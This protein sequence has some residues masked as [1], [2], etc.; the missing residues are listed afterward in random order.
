MAAEGA[1]AVAESARLSSPSQF[2]EKRFEHRVGR[3][4]DFIV[5]EPE[6]P[7]AVAAHDFGPAAIDNRIVDVLSAIEFNDEMV[8]LAREVR[9]IAGDRML[10]AKLEARELAIAQEIP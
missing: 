9:E 6:H 7:P 3:L 2:S 5:P 10:P 4:Q 1:W 8:L